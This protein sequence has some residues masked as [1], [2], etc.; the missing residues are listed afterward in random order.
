MGAEAGGLTAFDKLNAELEDAD[1]ISKEVT[2]ELDNELTSWTSKLARCKICKTTL[3]NF[4]FIQVS[5][6]KRIGFYRIRGKLGKGAF[7]QV[8]LGMHILTKGKP[9]NIYNQFFKS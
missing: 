7:S 2:S 1:A 9:E 8:K 6:G 4:F 3:A 5:E